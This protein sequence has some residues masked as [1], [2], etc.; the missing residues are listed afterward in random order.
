[1]IKGFA[2]GRTIFSDV[3]RRWLSGEIGDEA[4]VAEMAGHLSVLVNA[5][6]DARRSVGEAA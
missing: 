1:M 6:R 4:A 5:W 2:V 3:A